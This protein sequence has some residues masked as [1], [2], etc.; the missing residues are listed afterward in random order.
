LI[1]GVDLIRVCFIQA[2]CKK[3][4]KKAKMMPTLT[5]CAIPFCTLKDTRQIKLS[6]P[7]HKLHFSQIRSG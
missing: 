2:G 3:G 4:E 6:Q 7:Q 1:E 5:Q